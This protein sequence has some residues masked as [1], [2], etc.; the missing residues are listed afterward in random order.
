MNPLVSI[1]VPAFNTEFVVREAIMSALAQELESV[2]GRGAKI[3]VI[4]VDDGSS[5]GTLRIASEIAAL[6]SRVRVIALPQNIGTFAARIAGVQ[7]AR[8]EFVLFLDSDDMLP[9]HCVAAYLHALHGELDVDIVFANR[10][11]HSEDAQKITRNFAHLAAP[12]ALFGA[13]IFAEVLAIKTWQS[14]RWTQTGKLYTRVI[15]L[16][17]IAFVRETWG[18]IPSGIVG[19]EDALFSLA[20]LQFAQKALV[21][22][23]IL[24]EYL[25]RNRAEKMRNIVET[26]VVPHARFMHEARVIGLMQALADT[27]KVRNSALCMHTNALLQHIKYD[28]YAGQRHGDVFVAL[29]APDSVQTSIVPIY[30]RAVAS[31]MRYGKRGRAILRMLLFMISLGRIRR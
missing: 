20:I 14:S 28:Y 31:S 2:R 4:L 26:P 11:T 7:E 13:Q 10:M 9:K 22:D 17:A 16:H 3:E 18:E 15:L 30:L 6:D 21:I 19:F 23:E 25:W 5:D 29:D 8:G 1:I 27:Q 12:C 24:Y